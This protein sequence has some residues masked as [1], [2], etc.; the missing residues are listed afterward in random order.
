VH[1]LTI[2]GN[3]FLLPNEVPERIAAVVVD[4][5]VQAP[6]QSSSAS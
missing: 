4:A 1:A 3:V 5:A 6:R 2:P